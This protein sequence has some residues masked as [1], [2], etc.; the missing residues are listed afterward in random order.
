M[1]EGLAVCVMRPFSVQLPFVGPR[2]PPPAGTIFGWIRWGLW[3]QVKEGW[4]EVSVRGHNGLSS[5]LV[6]CYGDQG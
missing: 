3:G 6:A 5:W 1:S 4:A 2:G